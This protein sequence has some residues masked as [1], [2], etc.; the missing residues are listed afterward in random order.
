MIKNKFALALSIGLYFM[1]SFLE[2][3]SYNLSESSEISTEQL[4]IDVEKSS[5]GD[6]K[7]ILSYESCKLSAV[8]RIK[9]IEDNK[10]NLL[11]I[12]STCNFTPQKTIKLLGA[13]IER[14]SLKDEIKNVSTLRYFVDIRNLINVES[15][16]MTSEKIEYWGS[17]KADDSKSMYC[18]SFQYQLLIEK[19]KMFDPLIDLFAKYERK[20]LFPKTGYSIEDCRLI[21]KDELKKIGWNE[22]LKN[23]IYPGSSLVDLF[24]DDQWSKMPSPLLKN[25]ENPRMN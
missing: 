24:F 9:S 2:V 18:D 10:F 17:K 12:D 5:N 20:L 14:S 23:N 13:L 7:Y 22:E 25:N 6:K 21:K 11:I 16:I 15:L 1:A 8:L 19:S 4:T 3:K